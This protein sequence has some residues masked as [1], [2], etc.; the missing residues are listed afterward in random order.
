MNLAESPQKQ[1]QTSTMISALSL[2]AKSPS[3]PTSLEELVA[4]SIQ[5]TKA[6][7]TTIISTIS[8]LLKDPEFSDYA[9]KCLKDCSDNY[10]DSLSDLDDALGAFRSRDFSSANIKISAAMNASATCEDRF[11][12]GKEKSPLTGGKKVYFELNAMSLAFI[13]M[14]K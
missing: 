2:K 11:K 9:K 6:N 10:S 4:K 1:T 12:E 7:G 13:K 5:I 3:P 8:N 14:H